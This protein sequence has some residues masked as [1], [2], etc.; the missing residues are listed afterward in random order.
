[1]A[2]TG[3]IISTAAAKVGDKPLLGD[4]KQSAKIQNN[5]QIVCTKS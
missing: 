5:L 4:A 2:K 3:N 1:M